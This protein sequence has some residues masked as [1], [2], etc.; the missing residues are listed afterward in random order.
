MH[1]RGGWPVHTETV[2]QLD[3]IWIMTDASSVHEGQVCSDAR[4]YICV[5]EV[6]REA[7]L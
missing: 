4:C 5:S 6:V 3:D 7:V 2:T 1:K